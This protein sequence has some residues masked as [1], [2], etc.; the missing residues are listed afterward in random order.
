MSTWNINLC[1]PSIPLPHQGN[2]LKP[3]SADLRRLQ[4][5]KYLIYLWGHSWSSAIKRLLISGGVVLMPFKNPH[6][7]FVTSRLANCTGCFLR[8]NANDPDSLCASILT[9]LNRTSDSTAEQMAARTNDFAKAA[10]NMPSILRYMSDTLRALAPPAGI[11]FP[12]GASVTPVTGASDI[13]DELHI[14]GKT[15]PR[16]T[17]AGL[18]S[19]HKALIGNRGLAWQLD[20]WF[21]E[22]CQFKS[23][24]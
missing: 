14:G 7:S 19:S 22:N 24:Q 13:P 16:V 5:Y 11:P 3:V 9:R 21:D 4:R 8:Y 20:E 23:G 2:K 17:C 6:E 1:T 12:D 18:I 10:F 15:L